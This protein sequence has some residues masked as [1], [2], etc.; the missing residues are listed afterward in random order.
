MKCCDIKTSSLT[1]HI[2]VERRTQTR[3]TLGGLVDVWT[4]DPP[5]G[6]FAQIKPLSGT[7]A[8]VAHRIAPRANYH[9]ILRYRADENGAPYY[10][11]ADR[12]VWRGRYFDLLSSIDIESESRWLQLFLVE[13]AP[14]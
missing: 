14:S 13:G 7:E 1:E 5:E 4:A 10:T 12:V 8:Y 2:L 9:A 6:V 3:D 11:P